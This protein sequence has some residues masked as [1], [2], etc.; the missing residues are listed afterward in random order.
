MENIKIIQWITAKS[1][2]SKSCFKKTLL[3]LCDEPTGELDYVTAK[4]VLKILLLKQRFLRSL[5]NILMI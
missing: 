3:L 2:H 1:F 4:S 5:N